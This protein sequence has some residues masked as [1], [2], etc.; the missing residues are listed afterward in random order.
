MLPI[1][2]EGSI[3]SGLNQKRK[4]L[5]VDSVPSTESILCLISIKH[6]F[7][8]LMTKIISIF[9][10]KLRGWLQSGKKDH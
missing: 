4:N 3:T 10:K 8:I 9:N 2:S 1:E 5:A 7:K 6:F